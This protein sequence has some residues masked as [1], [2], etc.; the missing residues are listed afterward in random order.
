MMAKM[1]DRPVLT[2]LRYRG[3][4]FLPNVPARDLTADESASFDYVA[5][6][7]SGLYEPMDAPAATPAPDVQPESEA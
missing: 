3:G 2:M 4:G 6:L 7:A 5:L 1:A